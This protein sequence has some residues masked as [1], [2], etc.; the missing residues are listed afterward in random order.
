VDLW[1]T[2][3]DNAEIYGNGCHRDRANTDGAG[4]QFGDPTKPHVALFGDSHAANWFPALERLAQDGVIYLDSNTK[5]SCASAAVDDPLYGS[6]TI[7]RDRVIDRFAEDP[8]EIVVLANSVETNSG[9]TPD[10]SS[11]LSTTIKALPS[12]SRVVVFADVQRWKFDPPTCLSQR[13][14]NALDCSSPPSADSIAAT[15]EDREGAESSGAAFVDFHEYFCALQCPAIIGNTVVMRDNSHFT[16]TY[17][18]LL[19][20]I[21]RGALGLNHDVGSKPLTNSSLRRTPG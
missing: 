10:W 7:W 12:S 13:L 16:A 8:P 19:A 20:P 5:S 21:V 6:C 11:A 3:S 2:R 18:A 1:S 9:L 4:C 17:S 14:Y 15:V